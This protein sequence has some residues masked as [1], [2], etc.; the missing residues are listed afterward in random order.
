MVSFCF[1]N[2]VSSGIY[3]NGI[4]CS[5]RQL[6]GLLLFAMADTYRLRLIINHPCL[7]SSNKK[8]ID[9]STLLNDIS[10]CWMM[11]SRD[12]SIA[13]KGDF[14]HERNSIDVP[15]WNCRLC[16]IRNIESGSKTK[17]AQEKIVGESFNVPLTFLAGVLSRAPE[18]CLLLRKHVGCSDV[19]L[20]L[21]DSEKHTSN[22]RLLSQTKVVITSDGFL[23]VNYK[24]GRNGGLN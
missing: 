22:Y 10:M 4:F 1:E 21:I 24:F 3:S 13:I 20:Q 16:N 5:N 23:I 14:N 6:A 19:G 15:V 12:M 7:H 8:L 17:I 9:L 2:A 18:E 11:L